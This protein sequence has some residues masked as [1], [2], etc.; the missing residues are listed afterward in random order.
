MLCIVMPSKFGVC[1]PSY[2]TLSRAWVKRLGVVRAKLVRGGVRIGQ[3]LITAGHYCWDSNRLDGQSRRE[4]THRRISPEKIARPITRCELASARQRP[5]PPGTLH[6]ERV[7]RL[8][9]A[10]EGERDVRAPLENQY[11]H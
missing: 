1:A 3:S 4:S 10:L 9:D 2:R 7:R 5:R 6:V 8:L 11:L